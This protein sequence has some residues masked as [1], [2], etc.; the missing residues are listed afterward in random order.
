MYKNAPQLSFL[1][2]SSA[3]RLKFVMMNNQFLPA[4]PSSTLVWLSTKNLS[5]LNTPITSPKLLV[6]GCLVLT[7]WETPLD[8]SSKMLTNVFKFVAFQPLPIVRPSGLMP[9]L[10]RQHSTPVVSKV[11][12]LLRMMRLASLLDFFLPTCLFNN[13]LSATEPDV[14]TALTER[15]VRFKHSWSSKNYESRLYNSTLC[16]CFLLT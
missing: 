3:S 2:N 1:I 10:N 16:K 13:T 14:F 11:G 8:Y 4:S 15:N 5:L 7:N 6:L 9:F 12:V